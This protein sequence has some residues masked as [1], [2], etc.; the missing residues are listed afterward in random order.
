MTLT[1]IE[2]QAILDDDT[3]AIEG[4]IAW[5]DDEDHSPSVEFRAE[6][7]STPGWP[8]FVKGSYNRLARTLSYAIILKTTGRIYALDL[9]RDHHNPSCNRV[10][11]KHKHRWTEAQRDKDAYVPEDITAGADDPLTAWRQ[12]LAEARIHHS[13]TMHSPKTSMQ[14]ELWFP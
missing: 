5:S 9:G 13:G 2:F 10:G 3:K 7:C 14:A 6:V 8:L 11:E 12:F 1:N 4:D